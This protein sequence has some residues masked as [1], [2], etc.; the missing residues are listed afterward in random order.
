[1][2]LIRAA[3]AAGATRS[4]QEEVF[5]RLLTP[6]TTCSLALAVMAAC[7]PDGAAIE[8]GDSAVS[9]QYALARAPGTDF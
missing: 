9:H 8:H 5:R 7:A 3:A 1:M 6:R 2:T 4:D